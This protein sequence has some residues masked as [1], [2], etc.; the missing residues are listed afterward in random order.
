MDAEAIACG[1]AAGGFAPGAADAD[2]T[3]VFFVVSFEADEPF[4]FGCKVASREPG[5]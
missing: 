5:R 1:T 3:Q 4:A 2:F